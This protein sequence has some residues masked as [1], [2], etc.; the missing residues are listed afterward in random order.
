MTTVIVVGDGRLDELPGAA[1]EATGVARAASGNGGRV[2]GVFIGPEAAAVEFAKCG[3]DE[4]RHVART[5]KSVPSNGQVAEAV[6]TLA[7]ECNARL[8]VVNGTVRGR[9]LVGRLAVT[10]DAAAATNVTKVDLVSD[11]AARVVRPVFGGRAAQE[12]EL[13]GPRVVVSLKGHAF[14][15]GESGPSAVPVASLAVPDEAPDAVTG[16]TPS[17]GGS[18]PELGEAT[19]VV[20][21][22]RGLK[23]PES[24]RLVEE[25]AQSLGAAV[26][27]SR[28]V[29]DAGWRPGALQVGQTGKNVSPQ[30]YIAVGISGAIQHLVGMM[31]SRVIVAINSDAQAPI[32][33]VADYGI[34][35]DAFKI[36]PALTQQIR[37]VRG[38][39]T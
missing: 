12:L 34:V 7:H 37:K 33:R 35:G 18:G 4:V 28:A 3:V 39:P 1:R 36:L 10:W 15:A 6:A 24:F 29:T 27:A 26:G 32:F 11:A 16:F 25:L 19:I 22:G 20:S 13:S 8:I 17:G 5:E 21:G 14:A 23:S 9:D 30:L 38:L 31:S 2:V